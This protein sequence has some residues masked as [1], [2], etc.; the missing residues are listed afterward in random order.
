MPV[1]VAVPAAISRIA[2]SMMSCTDG[3][4]LRT[5]PVSLTC[6]GMTLWVWPPSILVTDST[7]SSVGGTRRE[8]IV[9]SWVMTDAAVRIASGV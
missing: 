8:T 2:P 3:L 6:A 7:A 1:A 5:V 9:L 4:K